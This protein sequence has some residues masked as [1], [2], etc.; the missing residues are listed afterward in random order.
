MEVEYGD[1]I[2]RYTYYVDVRVEYAPG[3]SENEKIITQKVGSE[4]EMS[5]HAVEQE[6]IEVV[7]HNARA[8]NPYVSSYQKII[9]VWGARVVKVVIRSKWFE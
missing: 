2:D 9:K 5:E 7:E 3:G 8:D 4:E 6:A 1:G